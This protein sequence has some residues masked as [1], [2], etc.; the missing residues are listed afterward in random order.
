MPITHTQVK[1]IPLPEK[2]IKI[3]KCGLSLAQFAKDCI[4]SQWYKLSADGQ[5]IGVATDFDFYR[6]VKD[7]SQDIPSDTKE[8]ALAAV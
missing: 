6:Q 5:A 1:G 3:T 8:K 7:Q 4:T 2:P